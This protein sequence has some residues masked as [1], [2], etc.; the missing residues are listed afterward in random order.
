MT[1]AIT[2]TGVWQDTVDVQE[3]VELTIAQADGFADVAAMLSA[4]GVRRIV[5]SGNGASFYVTHALWL[6]SLYGNSPVEL[7]GISTGLLCDPTFRWR[8][9]DVLLAV[10]SSGKL[11]DLIDVIENRIPKG[12]PVAAITAHPDAPV[13]SLAQACARIT[14]PHHRAVAHTGDFSAATAAALAIWARV[15]ED[16]GLMKAVRALPEAVGVAAEQALAWATADLAEISMPDTVVAFGTGP[17]WTAAMEAS[18]MVKEIGGITGE[19]LETREAATSA[20][21]ATAPGHLFVAL[22]TGA[23]PLIDETLRLVASRGAEVA[24]APGGSL[25]DP[26][27]SP[28]TTFPAAIA[29]SV[30]LG[31]RGGRDVDH[32]EWINTYYTTAR[33]NG[34]AAG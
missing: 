14:V 22:P 12:V 33:Q 2:G 29:L 15:S 34:T 18:L 24:T 1:E 13:P 4:P 6:A 28:V 25:G 8:E 21:T 23:D 20:L 3:A 9:G 30:L 26:R 5:A 16:G 7:L 19:G 10:S 11:R 32:P 27:V 17:V 31:L